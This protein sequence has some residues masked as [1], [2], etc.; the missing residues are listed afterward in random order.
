MKFDIAKK[1]EHFAVDPTRHSLVVDVEFYQM[2]L[3]G[4]VELARA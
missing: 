3:S 4:I 1:L 2:N